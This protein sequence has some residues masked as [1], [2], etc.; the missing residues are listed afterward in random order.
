MK[1]R[2]QP[3]YASCLRPG[4][5]QASLGPIAVVPGADGVADLVEELGFPRGRVRRG[6][7]RAHRTMSRFRR[8]GCGNYPDRRG[9]V[10]GCS[11]G[12]DITKAIPESSD[13]SG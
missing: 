10:H 5:R 3:T 7:A 8:W 6:S 13:V 9:V 12:E 11:R 4:L 1:R 2:I